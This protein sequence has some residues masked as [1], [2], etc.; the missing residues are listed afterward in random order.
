VVN[1]RIIK[2]QGEDSIAERFR[3][4]AELRDEGLIRHLGISNVRV[5]HLDEAQAIAPVV[6]YRTATRLTRSAP[7][8]TSSRSVAKGASRSS[9]SSQSPAPSANQHVLAI[10]GTGNPDHLVENIAADA[11]KLSADDLA[12]LD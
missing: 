5:D 8:T 12:S 7:M 9:R 4:L 11:L 3:A 1:L 6:S 10:P 2:K